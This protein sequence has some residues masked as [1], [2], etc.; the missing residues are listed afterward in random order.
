MN[1]KIL[2]SFSIQF[3]SRILCADIPNTQDST[4]VSILA[5]A[6]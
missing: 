4:A 2:V 5:A 6:N 3:H 1:N